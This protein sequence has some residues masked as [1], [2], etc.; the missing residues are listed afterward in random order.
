MDEI[1]GHEKI[2]DH[3]ISLL[4]RPQAAPDAGKGGKAQPET[5]G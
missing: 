4:W 1:L 3:G 5:T 2:P